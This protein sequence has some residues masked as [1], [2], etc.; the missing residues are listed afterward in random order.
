MTE[1]SES[2]YRRVDGHLT[3]DIRLQRAQKISVLNFEPYWTKGSTFA[4]SSPAL[5][6]FSIHIATMDCCTAR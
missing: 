2:Y 3:Y 5:D 4:A 6:R 1:T